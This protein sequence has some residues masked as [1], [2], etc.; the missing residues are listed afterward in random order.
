ML[1]I[2]RIS[3]ESQTE[4]TYNANTS[5]SNDN[6][7]AVI[8]HHSKKSVSVLIYRLIE[9]SY[10]LERTI[11]IE[12]NEQKYFGGEMAWSATGRYLAISE[13]WRNIYPKPMVE[14]GRVHVFD[15]DQDTSSAIN[16]NYTD[17]LRH[18][19]Y[20]FGDTVLFDHH[21]RLYV[22]EPRLG[23]GRVSVY[24]LSGTE[25]VVTDTLYPADGVRETITTL[26][27][28]TR[29]ETVLFGGFG[30]SMVMSEKHL[31]VCNDRCVF[32]YDLDSIEKHIATCVELADDKRYLRGIQAAYSPEVIL[33]TLCNN[34][35]WDVHLEA[36]SMS[37]DRVSVL[38]SHI[39]SV[40]LN[41]NGQVGIGDV[42]YKN[43]HRITPMV[44]GFDGT[45]VEKD[46][47]DD[48]GTFRTI[49]PDGKYILVAEDQDLKVFQ[50]T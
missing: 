41:K 50:L 6:T 9:G 34:N 10:T 17:V 35:T 30:R 26:D 48:L 25:R 40:F 46:I 7:L 11:P 23:G 37:G 19:N 12:V 24:T 21:D 39:D 5:F 1:E 18:G 3:F 13:G 22:G 29:F 14:G 33:V 16:P 15:L 38:D 27:D 45:F 43:G 2:S 42:M 49:S 20:G 8:R 36:R 31:Y 4:E 32:R 44:L 28:L 47:I